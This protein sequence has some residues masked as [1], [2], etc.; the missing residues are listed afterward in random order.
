LSKWKK[1]RGERGDAFANI[2]YVRTKSLYE[3]GDVALYAKDQSVAIRRQKLNISMLVV[4]RAFTVKAWEWKK[5]R[6][7]VSLF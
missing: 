7:K 5:H 4:Q 3:S 2:M 1:C 6:V